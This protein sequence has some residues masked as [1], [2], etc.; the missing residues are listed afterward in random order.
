MKIYVGGHVLVWLEMNTSS[1]IFDG[2]KSYYEVRGPMAF[3][4]L[5]DMFLRVIRT[6]WKNAK[7]LMDFFS[8]TSCHVY[9]SGLL[10][11]LVQLSGISVV[12]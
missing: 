5:L 11:L 1:K 6:R 3:F 12:S 4:F 10:F 7:K 8:M 2:R 9:L